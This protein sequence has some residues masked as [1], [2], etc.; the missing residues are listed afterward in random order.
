MEVYVRIEE[1]L[2]AVDP[3]GARQARFQPSRQRLAG[4]G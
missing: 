3:A 4:I 1:D 2:D